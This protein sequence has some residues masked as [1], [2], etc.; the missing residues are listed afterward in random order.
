MISRFTDSVTNSTI[1]LFGGIKG[2][3][4]DG[5]ELRN[6]LIKT[7]PSTILIGIS[8][9][10]LKGLSEFLKDP[11]ELTLSDYEMIYGV[12]LSSYGEV[13]TP[14]PIFTEAL[15]YGEKH[16]TRMI[17]LDMDEDKFGESFTNEIGA[18]SMIRHSVRKR[19][20]MK[21]QFTGETPEEFVDQWNDNIEKI[22]G[23]RRIE[24]KR[25]EEMEHNLSE[26]M[27]TLVD[28]TAV[29][30]IE[31]EKYRSMHRYLESMGLKVHDS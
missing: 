7:E 25:L 2:L 22:D 14:S 5:D 23:F 28:Q 10:E 6:L 26:S 27:K 8:P 15:Q 12:V 31:Y 29:V 11:F 1:F 3:I 9:E 21:K 17:A 24:Q 18:W 4:R 13:M 20:L 30:V 16:S 19:R